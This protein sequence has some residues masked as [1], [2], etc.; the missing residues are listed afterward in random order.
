MTRNDSQ[1][2]KQSLIKI[3]KYFQIKLKNKP[4]YNWN[5]TAVSSKAILAEEKPVWLRIQRIDC[6]EA[7]NNRAWGGEIDA[8]LLRGIQKST[9]LDYYDWQD[10]KICWRALLLS[11]VDKKI[12][13][14][15]PILIN[16]NFS[17]SIEWLK[18]L[19]KNLTTL[20]KHKT[21]RVSLTQ[22]NI[23]KKIEKIFDIQINT[24]L[25]KWT[26]IH[27]DLHWANLTYPRLYI[28]DWDVWGKG[29]LGYDPALLLAFSADSCE[30]VNK[31][32]NVF[33]DWLST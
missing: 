27:G 17:P 8:R 20:S 5:D 1:Q 10:N 23:N 18:E 30:V 11:Y 4:I 33:E 29:P 15:H 16:S 3:S 22:E 19:K 25:T 13:S 21:N 6:T 2:L 32:R 14:T 24:T 26:T 9:L 28:L 12:C 31:I 7:K